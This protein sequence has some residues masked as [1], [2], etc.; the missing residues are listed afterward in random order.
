MCFTLRT[1]SLQALVIVTIRRYHDIIKMMPN[2]PP[3]LQQRKRTG[4]SG[5]VL[6]YSRI[7]FS[8]KADEMEVEE[9]S[10]CLFP[11]APHLTSGLQGLKG[12]YGTVRI[13]VCRCRGCWWGL[14]WCS[15]QNYLRDHQMFCL[16][17]KEQ[18][19]TAIL[20]SQDACIM[21]TA[22]RPTFQALKPSTL[23]LRHRGCSSTVY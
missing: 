8:A 14:R 4:G 11:F 19:F 3:L 21:K 7:D 13:F 22:S 12:C 18:S 9:C 6:I 16:P 10:V 1:F 2:A 15:M 20:Q 23:H 5:G 17:C